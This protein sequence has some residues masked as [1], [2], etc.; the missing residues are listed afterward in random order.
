[1]TGPLCSNEHGTAIESS[2]LT[3]SGAAKKLASNGCGQR[4]HPAFQVAID[5]PGAT[6][7]SQ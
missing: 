6:V 4:L 3:S 2:A 1:M 7:S 5:Q